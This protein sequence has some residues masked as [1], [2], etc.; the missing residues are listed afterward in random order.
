MFGRGLAVLNLHDKLYVEAERVLRDA[1]DPAV[2]IVWIHA[3]CRTGQSSLAREI[4]ADLSMNYRNVAPDLRE[5]VAAGCGLTQT[6]SR[7]DE[8]ELIQAE[9]EILLRDIAA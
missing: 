3:L 1:R 2:K 4:Y 9:C 8:P 5:I 6:A 7:V